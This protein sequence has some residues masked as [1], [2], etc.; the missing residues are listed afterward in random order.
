MLIYN[1]L[2]H[3][4]L[5]QDTMHSESLADVPSGEGDEKARILNEA[6]GNLTEI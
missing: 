5:L 6:L 4:K 3:C 1:E 2:V